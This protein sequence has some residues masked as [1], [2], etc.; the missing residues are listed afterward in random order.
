M[1]LPG[2]LRCGVDYVFAMTHD[3][4]PTRWDNMIAPGVLTCP[5]SPQPYTLPAHPWIL[6]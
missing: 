3:Y 4:L 1:H 6:G 2:E 5:S